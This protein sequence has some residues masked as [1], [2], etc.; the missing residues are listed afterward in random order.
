[1][2]AL[3]ENLLSP[4][5]GLPKKSLVLKN[6]ESLIIIGICLSLISC[7]KGMPDLANLRLLSGFELNQSSVTVKSK[8]QPQFTLTGKC[9]SQFYD[10][11]VSF[12]DGKTW[13]PIKNVTSSQSITCK[14]DGTFSVTF[15]SNLSSFFS[16][17]SNSTTTTWK[18]RALSE[19]GFSDVKSLVLLANPGVHFISSGAHTTSQGGLVLK[20][21]VGGQI[22]ASNG[23]YTLKGSVTRK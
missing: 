4:W 5:S 9:D 15:N 10:L 6:S 22:Q 16:G 17:T 18:F 1:M 13:K 23:G 8:T 14:Q 21:R 20:G 11:D 19:I 12:D 2:T 3:N 7:K